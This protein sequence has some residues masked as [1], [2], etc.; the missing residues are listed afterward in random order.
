MGGAERDVLLLLFRWN[1]DEEVEVQ[2]AVVF[3]TC[4][5]FAT[6]DHEARVEANVGPKLPSDADFCA[7]LIETEA[8]QIDEHFIPGER[9]VTP[10]L[11]GQVDAQLIA[12]AVPR[13]V[14][15]ISEFEAIPIVPGK[16]AET[17]EEVGF[18]LEA[19]FLLEFPRGMSICVNGSVQPDE[20]KVRQV[21]QWADAQEGL[22]EA[23]G[24][25]VDSDVGKRSNIDPW[26][27]RF[28]RADHGNSILHPKPRFFIGVSNRC[29]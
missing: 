11:G 15:A 28:F 13:L 27:T 5:V 1:V 2:D 9:D 19:R 18:D 29:P 24:S 16:Y 8:R 17:T 14:V 7:I 20:E 3:P 23:I 26:K 10:R 25:I 21:K 12:V 6:S 4:C 22:G